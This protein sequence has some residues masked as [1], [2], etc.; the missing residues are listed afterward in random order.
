MRKTTKIKEGTDIQGELRKH[1]KVQKNLS[2][3]VEIISREQS[4]E[5]S[6]DDLDTRLYK[7]ILKYNQTEKQIEYFSEA[8][9]K[10]CEQSFTTK[11]LQGNHRETDQCPGGH[12]NLH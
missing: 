5:I 12:M 3:T 7:T 6:E 10:A 4:S 9:R 2:G 8:V 11:R 1:R